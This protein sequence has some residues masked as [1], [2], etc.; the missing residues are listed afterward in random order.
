MDNKL[1]ESIEN[2]LETILVLKTE[3]GV[4]RVKEIS[5]KSGVSM[6]SVH[7]AL[8]LL[9]DI[10]L[11]SHERYGYVDL[12][13]KGLAEARR[14]YARHISLVEFLHEVLGIPSAISERDACRMEHVIPEFCTKLTTF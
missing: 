1:S 5:K 11:V 7:T 14:I 12:T 3:S 4:V 13:K 2:Y 8:H 10:G 9:E 6:P